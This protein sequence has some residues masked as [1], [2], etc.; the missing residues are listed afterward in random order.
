MVKKYTVSKTI[1]YTGALPITINAD[2]NALLDYHIYG[3]TVQT[4]TPTPENPIMPSWCGELE[5]TGVHAGQ[6]KLPLTSAGQN[7]DI[8]LG[9]V[10][11]TRQINK[12]VLT[13]NE[14]WRAEF[15]GYTLSVSKKSGPFSILCTHYIPSNSMPDKSI[16][17][18]STNVIIIYDSDYTTLDD[19]KSYLSQQ[20]AA[21]TPV[22]VWYVRAGSMTGI[23]NEPLMKLG[24]YADTI[25]STQA[26]AQ[27][28]TF[29]G[30]TVID[31]SG[32][33]KPSQ[34]YVKYSWS[35]WSDIDNCK[36]YHKSLNLID[37]SKIT[38]DLLDLSTGTTTPDSNYRTTD[39]ISVEP[40]YRHRISLKSLENWAET[41]V[42]FA[43][44]DSDKGYSSG[45][46]FHLSKENDQRLALEFFMGQEPYI[47]F[48]WNI[49]GGM[50]EPMLN[51]GR[52]IPYEPYGGWHDADEAIRQNGVWV[53]Q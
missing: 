9:E 32:T 29:A 42:S 53:Q 2:G 39:Y 13:G 5:T 14:A 25:D 34:M 33:L 20:H 41:T 15:N 3:N 50:T 7:V 48:C 10:K 12:L 44:Y 30:T 18:S 19:F 6:Y 40:F 11:T 49:D 45:R 46:Q 1:E 31:Y 4:G 24:D 17:S 37:E 36:R 23:V 47:R 38:N 35:G 22:T 26:T 8:Y 16:Y 43:L 52:V 27:I 21:G 51:R 28:P